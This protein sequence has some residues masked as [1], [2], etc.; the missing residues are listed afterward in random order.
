MLLPVK[1]VSENINSEHLSLAQLQHMIPKHGELAV[2]AILIYALNELKALVN[3]GKNLTDPQIAFIAQCIIEEYWML[4]IVEVKYV[5][6]RGVEREKLFDR[7]DPN[8]VLKWFA[9]YDA[10]RTE[11]CM[12]ISHQQ[13][14]Q[15]ANQSTV[16]DDA[17][18]Y[19][20]WLDGLKKRAAD[21]DKN[22]IGILAE[23]ERRHPIMTACV[24]GDRTGNRQK[25]INYKQWYYTEYLKKKR[26]SN[27]Q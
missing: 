25:D 8:I 26:Q 7:L 16:P 14:T 12:E 3:V 23:I 13:E 2:Q 4:K 5:L 10:E 18:T 1:T 20:E 22:A 6:K 9:D 27:P 21:G 11:R 15:E 17:K 19:D 24:G